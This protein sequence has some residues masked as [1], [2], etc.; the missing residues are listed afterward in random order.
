MHFNLVLRLDSISKTIMPI[1]F[2]EN[3]TACV[4]RYKENA[5]MRFL[6]IYISFWVYVSF[7]VGLLTRIT[8]FMARFM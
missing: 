3:K 4:Q 8:S 2:F 5:F 7:R 1:S 6:Y